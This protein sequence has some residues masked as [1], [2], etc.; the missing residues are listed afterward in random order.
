VGLSRLKGGIEVKIAV[1]GCGGPKVF[2]PEKSGFF[3]LTSK[4]CSD[5]IDYGGCRVYRILPAT[6]RELSWSEGDFPGNK[7]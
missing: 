4:D 6:W 3:L 5:K 2:F 7:K 1:F